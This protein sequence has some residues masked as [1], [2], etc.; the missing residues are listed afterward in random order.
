MTASVVLPPVLDILY[1]EPLRAELL[2][3]R[4]EPV[5]VDASAVE[6][7]GGLCLQVLISAQQTWARDGQA[8]TINT[9]S[10][11]FATQWKMYGAALPATVQGEP[12]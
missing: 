1:A 4:G 5:A 11:P 7:L 12:A 3:L 8:L 6:R 9:P 10:E 2:A